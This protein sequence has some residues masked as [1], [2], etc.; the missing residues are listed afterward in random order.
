MR[1]KNATLAIGSERRDKED[2][3]EPSRQGSVQSVTIRSAV[4]LANKLARIAWAVQRKNR[5]FNR[6]PG[7]AQAWQDRLRFTHSPREGL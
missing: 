2:I 7:I 1:R 5:P 4:A 6:T 3:T